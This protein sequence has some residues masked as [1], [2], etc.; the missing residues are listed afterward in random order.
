MYKF[1]FGPSVQMCKYHSSLLSCLRKYDHIV[2]TLILLMQYTLDAQL[3]LMQGVYIRL[4]NKMMFTILSTACG[5]LTDI[6]TTDWVLSFCNE[7]LSR[8]YYYY[9]PDCNKFCCSYF[10]RC[11]NQTLQ[12]Q[13]HADLGRQDVL[14]RRG[15]PRFPHTAWLDT[16][17]GVWWLQKC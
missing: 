2:L 16:P 4:E 12:C 7:V 11:D 15:L 9:H 3:H 14:H 13:L 5:V 8:K 10:F 17:Q 6:G 1:I